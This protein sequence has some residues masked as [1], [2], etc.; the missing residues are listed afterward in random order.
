MH[1]VHTYIKKNKGSVVLQEGRSE[2]EN[3]AEATTAA[4]AAAATTNCLSG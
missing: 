2:R 4:A 3:Y 1:Y